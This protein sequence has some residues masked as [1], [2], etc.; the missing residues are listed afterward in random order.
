MIWIYDV[1]SIVPTTP[2]QTED[3]V[4][5]VDTIPAE[6]FDDFLREEREKSPMPKWQAKK[7]AEKRKS[8][9][10]ASLWPI[11]PRSVSLRWVDKN[12]NLPISS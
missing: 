11:P 7:E 6:S 2:I 4:K 8:V 1:H 3:T 10:P 12:D 5:K 9:D